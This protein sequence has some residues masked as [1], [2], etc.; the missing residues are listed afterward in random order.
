MSQY[1]Y[2]KSKEPPLEMVSGTPVQ[3]LWHV[4]NMHEKRLSM[5][6]RKIRR[7]EEI[8][9][10]QTVTKSSGENESQGK[11]TTTQKGAKRSKN[12]VLLSISE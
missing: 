1:N 6:D 11:Q 8:L 5:M 12:A 2:R 4:A 9:M 7:L 3:Q 10:Q